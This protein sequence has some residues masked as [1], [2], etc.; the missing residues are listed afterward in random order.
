MNSLMTNNSTIGKFFRESR[1][2]FFGRT[3]EDILRNDPIDSFDINIRENQDV[4]T[5]EMG[6]PGMTRRDITIQVDGRVMWVSAQRQAENHSWRTTEFA[7]KLFHRSFSLPEDADTSNIKAKCRNGLLTIEI[8]KAKAT[9][10]SRVIPIS[11]EGSNLIRPDKIT[12]WWTQ[13]IDKGRALLAGSVPNPMGSD[14]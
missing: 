2:T 13:L 3:I 5:L 12:S 1:D 9:R 14:R 10:A 7:N 11:G 8:S 6:V 4:Y